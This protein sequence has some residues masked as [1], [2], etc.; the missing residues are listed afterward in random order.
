MLVTIKKKRDSHKIMRRREAN[1]KSSTETTHNHMLI[2]HDRDM[3]L[4]P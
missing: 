1:R 4:F 3:D 2:S